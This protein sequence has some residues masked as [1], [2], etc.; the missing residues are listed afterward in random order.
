MCKK[1]LSPGEEHV[2]L[3][4]IVRVGLNFYHF[5]GEMVPVPGFLGQ[6]VQDVGVAE[7]DMIMPNSMWRL[8]CSGGQYR[9]L[10]HCKVV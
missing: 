9:L 10:V 8:M 4:H 3:S 1:I 5:H 7:E 6:D 2:L